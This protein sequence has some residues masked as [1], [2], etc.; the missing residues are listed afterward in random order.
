MTTLILGQ[1]NF[2]HK[3]FDNDCKYEFPSA[4]LEIFES[5]LRTSDKIGP[6]SQKHLT[7]L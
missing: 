7:F 6:A 5:S 3:V 4:L 1:N 2:T